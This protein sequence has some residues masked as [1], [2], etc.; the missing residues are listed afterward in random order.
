MGRINK[1]TEGVFI[2]IVGNNEQISSFDSF[3]K[4]GQKFN[5]NQNI[6]KLVDEYA[7]IIE[8]N[9]ETF[10]TLSKIE[11]VIIQMRSAESVDNIKLSLVRDYVYARTPF[12][13]KNKQGKDIRVIIDKLEFYNVSSINDLYDNKEFMDNAKKKLI[14]AMS[15]EIHENLFELENVNQIY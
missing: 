11:E 6:K 3:I 1:T 4:Y 7:Y 12:F 9:K 15:I 2:D 13:R 8:K 10:I 5:E 14:N